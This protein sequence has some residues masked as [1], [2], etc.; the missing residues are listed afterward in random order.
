MYART[1]S[2]STSLPWQNHRLVC[3]L[4]GIPVKYGEILRG[5]SQGG[6]G[7]HEELKLED[8][9][10]IILYFPSGGVSTF[11]PFYGLPKKYQ[12]LTPAVFLN[13][14]GEF[15]R[16]EHGRFYPEISVSV[17]FNF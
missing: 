10:D 9:F 1:H 7:G 4:N 13:N 14:S 15:E 17:R 3:Y 5:W 16:M 6:S 8:R 12:H 2:F 11:T